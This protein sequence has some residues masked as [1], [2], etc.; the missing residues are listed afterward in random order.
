M[1]NLQEVIQLEK[2]GLIEREGKA[3]FKTSIIYNGFADYVS[4]RE[5]SFYVSNQRKREMEK[6]SPV[7]KAHLTFLESKARLLTFFMATFHCSISYSAALL[8]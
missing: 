2:M 3:L 4:R 5:R 6:Y 8:K 1:T 7:E